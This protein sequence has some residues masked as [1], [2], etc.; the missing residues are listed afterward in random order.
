MVLIPQVNLSVFFTARLLFLDL[1]QLASLVT[2]SCVHL[3]DQP[4][5]RRSQRGENLLF[6]HDCHDHPRTTRRSLVR[7]GLQAVT[8][9]ITRFNIELK[10]KN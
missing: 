5:K 1:N 6:L 10:S 2:H 8:T 7:N 9:F 3:C 4:P